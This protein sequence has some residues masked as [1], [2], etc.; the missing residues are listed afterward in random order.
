MARFILRGSTLKNIPI[1]VSLMLG[2]A[3][4]QVPVALAQ[5]GGVHAAGGIAHISPPP[6]SHAPVTHPPVSH[7]PG[8]APRFSPAPPIGA[9]GPGNFRYR[10]RPIRP[11]PPV[12]PVYGYPFYFGFPYYYGFAPG[13]G[14][15]FNSCWSW[16]S[17][18]LFWN[19][20]LGY[21]GLGYNA[22]PF[23]TYGPENYAPASAYQYPVYGYE[24]ER[25][26]LP[27]L[28][29]KDGTVV[30]VTDYWLANG[31]IHFTMIEEGGRAALEH[32]IPF[33]ELDLQ[34]TIDV[35][36]RHGFRFVL[37]NEPLEQYLQDHPGVTP[38]SPPSK[39][40]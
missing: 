29:L 18:D 15:G 22:A 38:P 8:S 25:R 16:A 21:T 31:Q 27:Q 40:N 13:W 26:D 30:T 12:F 34:T 39:K 10:W 5:H 23:Y 28:Y 9:F 14:W 17:C 3:C 4:V 37:R 20:G 1:V 33:D 36:T 6:V 7:A 24:D 19:W 35:A 11:F 2:A 32:V